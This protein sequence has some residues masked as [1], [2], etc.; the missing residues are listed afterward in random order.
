MNTRRANEP[1]PDPSSGSGATALKRSEGG[2]EGNSA[3]ARGRLL[4]S[5]E[6]DEGGFSRRSFLKRAG[7]AALAAAGGMAAVETRAAESYSKLK[8]HSGGLID[9]NVTLGRWPF[10]RLPL[11]HTPG[12][13]AKLCQHGVTQAWAGSFDAVFQKDIAAANVWR[14]NVASTGAVCSCRSVR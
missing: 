12:L 7:V 4:P 5:F 13:V 11:D 10:R 8:P 1:T 2:R 3:S 14:Q 9:T 6:G